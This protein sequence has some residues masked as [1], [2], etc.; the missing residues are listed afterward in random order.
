MLLATATIVATTA[1]TDAVNQRSW[2]SGLWAYSYRHADTLYPAE[3]AIF[4]ELRDT[5]ADT[6]MLDLGIGTGRT[7]L[8]LAPMVK[9]YVGLD[10]SAAMID[11]ARQRCPGRDLHVADARDL[12]RFPSASFDI[13]LFSFNGIDYVDH[14][15]RC[16]ILAEAARVLR[17]GGRLIFSSHNRDTPR[18]LAWSLTNLR[19]SRHPLRLLRG[20]VSYGHG[21]INHARLASRQIET[22][23]YEVRNDAANNYGLL[24]YYIRAADQ[25]QHLAELGF[26]D[27]KVVNLA[28]RTVDAHAS[29]SDYM[30][31]YIAVRG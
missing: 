13:A 2:N 5:L 11:R 12:S 25:C 3:A 4:A 20:V 30:L 21:L 15:G 8:N 23:S 27:A 22:P 10:Y 29:L 17:P 19:L 14:A 18:T 26:A 6:D 16:A 28:G 7:T 31:H 1:A 24:T 9:R